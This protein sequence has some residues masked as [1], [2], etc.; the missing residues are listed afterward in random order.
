MNNSARRASIALGIFMA[1]VLVGSTFLQI[2]SQNTAV[3]PVNN[4]QATARIDPTFP[5]PLDAAGITYDQLFLHPTGIFAIAQPTGFLPSDPSSST[6]IAQVN[7]VNDEALSVIDAFVQNPGGPITAAD[8]D[9]Y[10][11]SEV[12]AAS[13]ANFQNWTENTRSLDGDTLSIDFSVRLNQQNYVA[14]QASWTDGEWIYVIRVLAPE[15]ATQFLQS[16]LAS[17]RPTLVPFKQFVGQPFDWVLAYDPVGSVGIRHP[18]DWQVTDSAPGRPVSISGLAGE[19][20]RLETQTG[21]VSDADAASAW[22]VTARPGAVVTSAEP[23]TRGDL[24]GFAV[25]YTSA[26]VDGEPLSGYALLLNGA[27]NQLL[28]ANLRFP[29]EGVNLNEVAA[30]VAVAAEST[31][32][33][34]ATPEA[35]DPNLSYY[36]QLVLLMDSFGGLPRLNFSAESLPPTPTVLPTRTPAPTSEAT[37]EA[38]AEAT[39]EVTEVV[40]EEATPTDEPTATDVPTDEPTATDVPTEAPTATD[41]PTATDVPTEA[42]TA[43]DEPTATNTR[44]PRPTATDAEPTA[45]NTRT[46]RPTRTPSPT[47]GS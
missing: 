17:L 8:L 31:P 38:T 16:V 10:F 40:T 32:D 19:T 39:P 45:T 15:N 41:E 18:R 21:S 9:S 4:A 7:M 24:S 2:F 42:P 43:T 28:T 26:T 25:S 34:E 35:T 46:P 3:A 22:V 11:T 29:A 33:P 37:E 20:L 44:T 47:P 5:P 27:D 23:L 30:N 12:L 36:Q 14:R 6:F 13:W 1:V